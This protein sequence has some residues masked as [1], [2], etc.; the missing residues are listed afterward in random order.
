VEDKPGVVYNTDLEKL[1][2]D[3]VNLREKRRVDVDGAKTG[4]RI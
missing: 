2:K 3:G 1:S 4:G